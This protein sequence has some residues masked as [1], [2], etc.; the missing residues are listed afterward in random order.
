MAHLPLL[1]YVSI[2]VFACARICVLWYHHSHEHN[3]KHWGE[4]I[5]H[6]LVTSKTLN[7]ILQS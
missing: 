6:V 5:L 7:C 1:V 2:L 3:F 4:S